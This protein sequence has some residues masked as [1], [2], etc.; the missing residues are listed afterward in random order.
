MSML[1]LIKLQ[2]KVNFSISA[3]RWYL[4]NDIKRFLGHIGLVSIVVVS[5]APIFYLY[6]WLLGSAYRITAML[7]QTEVILALAALFSS[8]LVLIF[9]FTYLLSVFYFSRDLSLLVPLPLKPGDILGAKFTLVLFYNYLTIT[10]FYLPALWV[11]GVNSGAGPLYWIGGAVIFL[12][13]PVIPMVIASVFILPLMGLTNLSRRRDTLR[14]IGL[15]VFLVSV[16]VLNYFLTGIP[17][18]EEVQFMERVLREEQGLVSLLTRS[19]PP[20]LFAALALTARGV[21]S[22]LNFAYFLSL[23]AAGLIIVLFLGQRIFYQGLIGGSEVSRG[24]E[25]SRN[26]LARKT[27]GALSPVWAIARRE[28]KYLIRT[29]IYLFNSLAM[30]AILPAALIIPLIAGGTLEQSLLAIQ[31]AVPRVGQV[32]GGAGFIGVMALFAPAASSSFSREGKLFWISKVIPI[33]PQEQIRGKLLYSLLIACSAVPVVILTAL[34]FLPWSILDF[35]LAILGGLILS[36]PAIVLSL[37]IDL[38]KPYLTWDNPQKAIKQNVN[39]LF[40]MVAGGGLYY[41]LY[42]AGRYLYEATAAQ[43]P[44]YLFVLGGAAVMGVILYGVLMK[45]APSRY[46]DIVV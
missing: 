42:L 45:I 21:A 8:L 46:R 7:G 3:L 15:F 40:S 23:S 5:V 10:P 1:R 6:T 14:L 25:L 13:L 20:A 30:V 27:A 35:L 4:R 29:P 17:A 22:L 26:E 36:F 2:L 39:V 11:Y 41:L 16:F 28:I 43:L 33:A 9:G 18:G 34:L 32:L 12:L 24:R 37:L 38:L 19:Y 44:V 31:A